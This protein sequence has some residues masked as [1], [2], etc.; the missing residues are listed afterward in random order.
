LSEDYNDIVDIVKKSGFEKLFDKLSDL[1]VEK[2]TSLDGDDF[3]NFCFIDGRCYRTSI[4]V[5]RNYLHE[6]LRLDWRRL[7]TASHKLPAMV[8]ESLRKEYNIPSDNNGELAASFISYYFY[9]KL[10]KKYFEPLMD[11]PINESTNR[12]VIKYKLS[13]NEILKLMSD[14]EYMGYDEE[15]AID[16]LEDLVS[17]LNG[18]N[19]PLTLY[20]IVCSDSK[21]ELNLSKVGSHYSL[22]KNNLLNNHYRRGSIAGDCRGEK[23]FLITVSVEKSM[24]D[25]METLSN[26]ILYPHE[27]EITLKN[28]GIGAV[29][30]DTKEL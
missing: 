13:K 16:D 10:F 12:N 14:Y 11:N 18:L 4:H 22:N 21:E 17:Y 20:R 7:I 19:S 1:M 27:E 5:S 15:S 26:N 23:V 29:V 25:V 2:S 6:T 8:H 28:Y 30:L 24:I 3:I 9:P